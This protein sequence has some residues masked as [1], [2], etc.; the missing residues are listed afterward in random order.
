MKD[1]KGHGGSYVYSTKAII[2]MLEQE[3]G[4]VYVAAENQS[5]RP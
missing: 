4:Q 1:N 5:E 3:K 2:D